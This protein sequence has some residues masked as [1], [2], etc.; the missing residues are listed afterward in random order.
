MKFTLH[1]GSAILLGL[2]SGSS[3]GHENYK[4]NKRKALRGKMIAYVLLKDDAGNATINLSS[5]GLQSQE[6]ILR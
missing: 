1:L 2:E 6:I 3:T 5:A 4:S